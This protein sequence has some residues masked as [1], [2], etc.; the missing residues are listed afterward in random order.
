MNHPTDDRLPS[1]ADRLPGRD[2]PDLVANLAFLFFTAFETTVDILATSCLCL[3]Q[4]MG[5]QPTLGDHPG[6]ITKVVEEFV[7]WLSPILYIARLALKTIQLD[8][9][10]I[11]PH[12]PVFQLLGCGNYDGRI[13]R[14]R[15]GPDVTWRPNPH[16]AFGGGV[17]GRA[18]AA[19]ARLGGQAVFRRLPRTFATVSVVDE[20][21]RY[22]SV[23]FRRYGSIPLALTL[24]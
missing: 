3:A 1:R 9:H 23:M 5:F 22:A 18:R 15:E 7:R 14:A 10:T 6:P 21:I 20:A 12:R 24:G 16:I 2:R 17:R 19:L 11:R 13:F 4:D 8:G